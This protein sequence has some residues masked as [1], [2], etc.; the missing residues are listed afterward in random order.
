MPERLGT[1][2]YFTKVRQVPLPSSERQTL[3]S[4]KGRNQTPGSGSAH[5][6]FMIRQ[7]RGAVP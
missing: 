5:G 6:L 4:A 7:R 3:M 1:R 2:G